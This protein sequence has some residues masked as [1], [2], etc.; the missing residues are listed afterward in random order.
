MYTRQH[1]SEYGRDVFA[2]SGAANSA[3]SHT[4]LQL[5]REGATLIRGAEDLLT[6]LGL[7]PDRQRIERKV[8]LDPAERRVLAEVIEPSLPDRLAASLG[9]SL[10]EVVGSLLRRELRRCAG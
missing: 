1:A 7:G 6:D 3:L 9:M 5:V 2:I 10:P 8:E 4:P